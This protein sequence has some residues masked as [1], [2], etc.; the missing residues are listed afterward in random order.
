[1]ISNDRFGLY[2]RMGHGSPKKGFRTGPISFIAQQDIN[3]LP[4]LV[5]GPV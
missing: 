4:M 5:H 1:M 2:L 3:N